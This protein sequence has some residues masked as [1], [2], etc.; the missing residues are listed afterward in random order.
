LGRDHPAKQP[1]QRSRI[2][3]V[4]WTFRLFELAFSA[5]HDQGCWLGLFHCDSKRPHRLSRALAILAWEKAPDYTW[6]I[7]HRGKDDRSMRNAFVAWHAYL[8][9]DLGGPA[10]KY[11][12]HNAAL[13]D[14]TLQ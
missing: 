10:N 7:R 9:F 13:K 11:I 4:D 3:A 1:H 14:T 6:T 12:G 2:S 8:G 5:V